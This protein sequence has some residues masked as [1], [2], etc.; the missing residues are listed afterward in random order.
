MLV[1]GKLVKPPVEYGIYVC[2][3]CAGPDGRTSVTCLNNDVI[4]VVYIWSSC[5]APNKM[6]ESL[7]KPQIIIHLEKQLN[8]TVY[9]TK[10][11]PCSAKFVALGSHPRNTGAVQIYELSKGELKL[12]SEVCAGMW[13]CVGAASHNRARSS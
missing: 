12:V 4:T 7:E 8:Y 5:L 1:K 11:I 6:A 3:L 10:W 9:D 2:V 13:E